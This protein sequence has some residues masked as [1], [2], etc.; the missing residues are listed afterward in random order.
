MTRVFISYARRDEST[1]ERIVHAL[2]QSGL[3][4]WR[5][6]SAIQP[7]DDWTNAIR[8]GIEQSDVLLLLLSPAALN[9]SSVAAE[10]RLALP[11]GKPLVIAEI[12]EVAPDSLPYVIANIRRVDL[13][14][15]FEQG[16]QTLIAAIERMI[17]EPALED[18]QDSPQMGESAK[19]VTLRVNLKSFEAK[20][21]ADLISRLVENGVADI[22][23]VN[24]DQH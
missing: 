9:S 21:F 17:T 3:T 6:A 18:T 23:V 12:E 2:E 19:H 8:L 4:I 22:Q 14:T 11:L 13:H 24:T 5:D 16:L 7:G 1:A 15:D 20:Q 10:Y